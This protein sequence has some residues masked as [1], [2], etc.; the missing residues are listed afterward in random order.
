[1]RDLLDLT[2]SNEL[3]LQVRKRLTE[4]IQLLQTYATSPCPKPSPERIREWAEGEEA[5]VREREGLVEELSQT[6]K[7]HGY[8]A[9]AVK[10]VLSS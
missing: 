4:V 3:H 6:M 1:M 5:E 9:E 10:A 7:N 8:D 2:L